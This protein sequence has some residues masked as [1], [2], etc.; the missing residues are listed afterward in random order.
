MKIFIMCFMIFI[1]GCQPAL[2]NI[3]KIDCPEIKTQ[4]IVTTCSVI[5]L[6]E[7]IPDN[8]YIEIHANK[9]IKIDMG[10][11]RLLRN[12]IAL[13]KTISSQNK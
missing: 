9:V 11:E 10:G 6:P 3:P 8:L 7:K 12:Y 2:I 1:V 4:P 5:E 13:R